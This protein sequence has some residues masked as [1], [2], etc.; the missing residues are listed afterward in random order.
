MGWWGCGIMS[1]DTPLDVKDM[2][3]DLPEIN[4]V[5]ATKFIRDLEVEWGC[6]IR[7]IRQCTAFCLIEKGLPIDYKIRE[8]ALWAIDDEIKEIDADEDCWKN[9]SERRAVLVEFRKIVEMYPDSGCKVEMPHQPGL[10]EM[11]AK[12]LDGVA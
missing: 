9:S 8:Y 5:T 11:F 12:Q 6:C 3:E 2:L 10:F 4:P 1:G 7:E